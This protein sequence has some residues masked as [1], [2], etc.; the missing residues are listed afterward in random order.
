MPTGY[1]VGKLFKISQKT[2]NLPA[3][4]DPLCLQWEDV[5]RLSLM[6]GSLVQHGGCGNYS[7]QQYHGA[8]RNYHH[9]EEETQRVRVQ[10]R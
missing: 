8:Q 2:L 7:V 6:G 5:G 1:I 4:Y 10:D 3:G 9:L